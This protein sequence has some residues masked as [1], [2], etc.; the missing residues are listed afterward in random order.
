MDQR[1]HYEKAETCLTLSEQADPESADRLL[2]AAQVHAHLA[3]DYKP[4][5][6][7]S[8]DR[9]KI[10]QIT[11]TD[12]GGEAHSTGAALQFPDEPMGLTENPCDHP[13][14]GADT[15]DCAPFVDTAP[16]VDPDEDELA[17]ALNAEV[18]RM[19]RTGHVTIDTGLLGMDFERN[20]A[21]VAREYIEWESR[22]A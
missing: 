1:T 21:R 22:D 14:H 3:G 15:H 19:V 7:W 9:A 16:D 11:L 10:G 17:H 12:S 6:E 8:I 13:N 18:V 4:P 2:K 20:L 5:E